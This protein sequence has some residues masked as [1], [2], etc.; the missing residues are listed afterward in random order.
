M[1]DVNQQM[2]FKLNF[3]VVE[4]YNYLSLNYRILNKGVLITT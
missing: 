4:I 3:L 2:Y 1:F